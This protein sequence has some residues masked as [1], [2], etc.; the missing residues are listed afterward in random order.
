MGTYQEE[1][2]KLSLMKTPDQAKSNE[3]PILITVAS[4]DDASGIARVRKETW[5]ATYPNKEFG[6]TREDILEK[7]FDSNDQIERWRKAIENH[8]GP[9]KI[10]V[11]KT[12]DGKLVG[13]SQGKKGEK[14]NEIYGLYVL[15]TYQGKGLGRELMKRVIDWL[16]EEKPINLSVA[17]YAKS[18]IELYKKFGFKEVDEPAEGPKFASG[19]V[20]PSIKMVKSEKSQI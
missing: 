2:I 19:A 16:G 14:E 1:L 9:R 17:T 15:P 11:A 10:W 4:P 7:N 13:Y 3:Q 5:L 18:A 8:T 12:K 20:A 6:V